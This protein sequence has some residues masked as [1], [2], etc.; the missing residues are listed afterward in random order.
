[1][2]CSRSAASAGTTSAASASP[3]RTFAIAS[4]RVDTRIGSIA[5]NS[6]AVYVSAFELLPAEAELG[7]AGEVRERHA[8]LLRPAG[9]RRADQHRDHDRVDH[10]QRHQQRRAPQDP[11]VLD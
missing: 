6:R 8:R 7:V 4:S 9:E 5:S 11:Q 2:A 3:S 10:E 1:M